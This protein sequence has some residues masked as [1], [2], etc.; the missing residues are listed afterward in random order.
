MATCIMRWQTLVFLAALSGGCV[1][2]PH[3]QLTAADSMELVA[4]TLESAIA[5]FGA[6]LD[7]LD[8]QRRKAVIEAFITRVHQNHADERALALDSGAFT[9]A[10]DRI[11]ADRR[12]ASDRKAAAVENLHVLREVADALRQAALQSMKLE[13]DAMQY[14]AGLLTRARTTTQPL[15]GAIDESNP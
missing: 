10:L 1:A 7:E 14:F 4:G 12:T 2:T 5:E 3:V 8:Q 11:E 15:T 9:A 6:D 13:D